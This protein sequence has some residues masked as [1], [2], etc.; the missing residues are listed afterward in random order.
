M[1]MAAEIKNRFVLVLNASGLVCNLTFGLPFVAESG[2]LRPRAPQ[3]RSKSSRRQ[4]KLRAD[5]AVARLMRDTR[6]SIRKNVNKQLT[7]QLDT[8]TCFVFIS[9]THPLPV[10]VSPHPRFHCDYY[11]KHTIEIFLVKPI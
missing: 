1:T 8:R 11:R 9:P 6:R 7:H 4:C 10:H 2:L 3:G 5:R